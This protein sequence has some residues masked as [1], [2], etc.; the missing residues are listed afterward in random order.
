M[1]LTSDC[2]RCFGLCCTALPFQR[3]SDFAFD[4]R[5]DTPCQHLDAGFACSIHL[6]LRADG[7]TGC[8]VFE[9]FGAGQ[10]VSQVTYGGV[11]WRDE[12]GT[13]SE[14]FAVF[15]R[16]RDLHELLVLLDEAAALVPDP[17]VDGLRERVASLAAADP[18]G[19]LAVDPFALRDEVGPVLERVSRQ[20]RGTGADLR[21]ADLAG[22]DLRDRVLRDADLRGALLVGADLRAVVLTRADLLGA[23]LRGADVAGA[24][25]SAALFLTQPQANAARGSAATRLPARLN[26]P[27][28]WV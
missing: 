1:D 4:K 23:D 16:V 18:A 26:R 19:V 6:T 20:V 8:T 12:P 21:H 14:M 11:S 7:M 17:D 10:H 28:H 2:S 25:L 9:C 27:G 22:T 5:P 15:A 24:D 13:A 3:S